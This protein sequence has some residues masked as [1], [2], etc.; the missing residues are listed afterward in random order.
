VAEKLVVVDYEAGNLRSVESAVAHLGRDFVTSADPDLVRVADRVIFP[1]VG[2]SASAMAVLRRTGLDDALREVLQVGQPMLG[3]CIGCQVIF[4]HS[5]ERDARCL[6]LLGGEVVAF[7]P[8]PER[9]VPHMGWNTVRVDRQH[10]VVA[11]IP[12]GSS[13]Y[14][15][16]SYYPAPLDPRVVIGSTDYGVEFASII[17]S[18]TL[19]ATQFHAEKSGRWGLQLLGNFLGWAP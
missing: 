4:D 12:S 17:G 14:F 15:V 7:E 3:I 16:H 18:A 2:E 6:G 19:V 11:G 10:P 1:G 5:E 9:K 13:F 8:D